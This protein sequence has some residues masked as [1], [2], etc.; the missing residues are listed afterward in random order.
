MPNE[1]IPHPDMQPAFL[2]LRSTFREQNEQRIKSL[3]KMGSLAVGPLG[4]QYQTDGKALPTDCWVKD[5]G[6]L[7]FLGD[8]R[9]LPVPWKERMKFT[10]QASEVGKFL[11]MELPEGEGVDHDA[12]PISDEQLSS[13][14]ELLKYMEQLVGEGV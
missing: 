11:L 13:D 9:F 3:L 5:D 6:V 10:E 12:P 2:E 4:Y 14:E 1:I 7:V 8:F